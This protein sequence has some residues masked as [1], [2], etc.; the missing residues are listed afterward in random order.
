MFFFSL[1]NSWNS[2]V[3]SSNSFNK[4]TVSWLWKILISPISPYQQPEIE[5]NASVH[6]SCM[7][8]RCMKNSCMKRRCFRGVSTDF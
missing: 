4:P 3:Y 7:K 1:K 6:A 2:N 5:A 8:N